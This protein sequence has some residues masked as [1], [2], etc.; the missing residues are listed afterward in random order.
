ML[1]YGTCV[2]GPLNHAWL[3]MVDRIR[4]ANKWKTLGVRV[5]LDQGVWGPFIV[6]SE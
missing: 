1:F 3:G 6:S 5:L 4:F 2:F